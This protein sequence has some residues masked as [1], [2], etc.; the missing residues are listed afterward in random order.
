MPRVLFRF[1]GPAAIA[2]CMALP[3]LGADLSRDVLERVG[4]F[5][6]WAIDCNAPSALDNVTRTAVVSS[7]GDATFKESLGLDSE[8]NEYVVLRTRQ[9][10]QSEI[11][12]RIKLNGER[13]QELVMRFHD[14]RIRTIS[15]RDVK[16]GRYLVKNGSV[17]G[18]GTDT[19]W[20]M[21]CGDA[22]AIPGEKS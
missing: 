17:R 20:L 3:A 15:N 9:L 22:S 13:E 19:P 11:A 6:T 16:T 21:R 4:F 10:G 2:S 5:G 18:T 7:T 8:P 14:G 1:L 12:L